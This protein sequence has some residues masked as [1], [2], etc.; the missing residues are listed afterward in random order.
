MAI[1]RPALTTSMKFGFTLSIVM[2]KFFVPILAQT[3][4]L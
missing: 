2:P 1:A 3:E 4:L